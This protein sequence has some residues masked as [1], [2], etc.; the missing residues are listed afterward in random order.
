VRHQPKSA[1]A[2]SKVAE[3]AEESEEVQEISD[4]ASSAP[5]ATGLQEAGMKSTLTDTLMVL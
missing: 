1:G 2:N 4:D 5:T 3:P